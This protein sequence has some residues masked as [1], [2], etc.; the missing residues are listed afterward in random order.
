MNCI[1]LDN[2]ATTVISKEALAAV[3][4]AYEKFGNPSSL[5][6]LGVAASKVVRDASD[7]LISLLSRD[8]LS[9][10]IIFTSGG[11]ESNS[12]ALL[13]AYHSKKRK[14]G[15]TLIISDSEHASVE[16]SARYLESLGV[17]VVRVPTVCGALDLDFLA[18]NLN[19]TVYMISIMSVN[20]ETGAV[21]DIGSAFSK[22]KKFNPDIITHTDAVQAFGKIPISAEKL[23]ADMITVSSHKVHGP[24]GVGALYVSKEIIK[25]RRLVPTV[26]GGG[27]MLGYRSGTE[28][29]PGIAGFGAACKY[30]KT[31]LL[32]DARKITA[33]REYAVSALRE[34]DVK[35][36]LPQSAAPHILSV[37]LP[38]IK[39]EVMLHYLSSAGI[40]VSSGSACSSNTPKTS[41]ALKA[42]GLSAFDADCT[43][44]ISLGN[45]NKNEDIDCLIEVLSEGIRTLIKRKK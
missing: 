19:S 29:Y 2:S 42:F 32:A 17:N 41:G 40:Y 26:H 23:K 34:L 13:G 39:S 8:R 37:T 38:G 22:A 25:T 3:S 33:V 35:L 28:N 21:Y 1:Y 43:I 20:N 24:M 9:G 31:D 11:T 30:L 12:L 10:N 15:D 6:S 4:E 5:H 14:Q 45:D 18:A 36:N 7:S 44:R 27:Q 16:E